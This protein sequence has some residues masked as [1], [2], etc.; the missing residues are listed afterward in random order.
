MFGIKKKD[1]PF[2]IAPPTEKSPVYTR[3]VEIAAEV[4]KLVEKYC[5]PP[6][7]Q[8]YKIWFSYVENKDPRLRR[9]IDKAVS[10][11][12][13]LSEFDATQIFQDCIASKDE[14]ASAQE[15]AG[16]KMTDACTALMTMLDSHIAVNYGY[17]SALASANVKMKAEPTPNNLKAVINT[18]LQENKKMRHHT[19][20][21]TN[22]LDKSKKQLNNL[23]NDLEKIRESSLIDPLTLV[24]NRK[25]FDTALAAQLSK[26]KQ[27]GTEFCLIL[28]DLDHFKQINDNFGHLVG[29][30]VLK[31]FAKVMVNNVKGQDIVARYGGE[32]FAIILPNTAIKGAILVAE[33]VRKSFESQDLQ[34]T[35][36][37]KAIGKITASFGVAQFRIGDKADTIFSRADRQL[38]NAK[39]EG[40]NRVA[41]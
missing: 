27:D 41:A 38:Y 26:G 25:K 4:F 28:A 32:E 35:E 13:V 24:G 40:R 22:R 12:G 23:T 8:N 11:S 3:A 31:V 7:P 5:S 39:N 14:F 19:N 6:H 10:S 33:L 34:V 16:R 29:D 17:T 30:A 37:G 36:N 1:N 20:K 18:L 9:Q 21:L 15:Q 2:S